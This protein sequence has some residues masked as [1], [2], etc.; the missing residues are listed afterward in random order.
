MRIFILSFGTR[1][2][3]EL[4]LILGR[5]LARRGHRV[6]FAIAPLYETRV[7]EAGLTALPFGQ[8]TFAQ[9]QAVLRSLSGLPRDQRADEFFNKWIRPQLP[10]ALG[11]IRPLLGEIDFFVCNLKLGLHRAGETFPGASITYDPPYSLEVLRG[12]RPPEHVGR[13]IEIVA[14]S[15][16]LVDPE[17][18]WGNEYHFTGFWDEASPTGWQ[19]P[20]DLVRFLRA[21][22]PPVVLAMGSMVTFDT[23][24]LAAAL[25]EALCRVDG[26]AIVVE[27]W[28]SFP[29]D[30]NSNGRIYVAKEI[31]YD[32]LFDKS[33]CVIHHGGCGTLSAV[34]RAGKPSILVPQLTCQE[35]FG[36]ML[37]REK[38]A[39]DVL[40][41]E[42]LDA[43]RLASALTR[44]LNDEQIRQSVRAW[45][46]VR[47]RERGVAAAA[48]LI[49]AH[50]REVQ[51]G[52]QKQSSSNQVPL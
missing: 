35:D 29:R 3:V 23:R 16:A 26:R 28:S 32:W 30:G 21:G 6:R 4:F 46:T 45:Q 43:A 33:C 50:W 25:N 31:P 24:R 48:D 15:K 5:E 42:S 49:E 11:R 18:L 51:S 10:A 1:G 2:D 41:I 40:D 12:T 44:A 37:T 38:L 47:C 9:L 39:V 17:G 27:G 34:L 13:I 7:L 36:N 22:S 20:A 52:G 8:G 14:L 19:P